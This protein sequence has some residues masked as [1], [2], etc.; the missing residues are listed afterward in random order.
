M[1]KKRANKKGQPIDDDLE[2]SAPPTVQKTSKKKGKKGKNK[3]DWS[4]DESKPTS[5]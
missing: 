1:S 5:K 4:D 3:D 2:E